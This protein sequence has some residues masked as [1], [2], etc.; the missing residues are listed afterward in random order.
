MPPK[1]LNSEEGKQEDA[2]VEEQL[3]DLAQT[4]QDAL[5]AIDAEAEAA[6]GLKQPELP[7]A[8]EEEKEAHTDDP[9][10]PAD[11]PDP[12]IKW[13]KLGGGSFRLGTGI[14]A[15]KIKPN[16][17]FEARLSE[18]PKGFRD[19]VVPVDP[20]ALDAIEHPGGRPVVGPSY[21]IQ[22]APGNQGLYNIVHLISGKPL[23]KQPLLADEAQEMFGVLA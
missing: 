1:D 17:F 11:D 15:K 3:N 5:A 19:V 22:D 16:Q 2:E 20:A 7:I 6:N 14:K 4:D 18:I 23:N 8:I 10:T 13:K 12:L 21:G 9:P